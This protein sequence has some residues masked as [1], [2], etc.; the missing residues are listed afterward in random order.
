[1][2][3]Q[4]IKLINI[5]IAFS[6]FMLCQSAMA[7]TL[8]IATDSGA[9]GSDAGNAI[10]EWAKKIEE[11]TNGEIELDIFYQNELGGQQEV[12]DLLMMG[13]VDLMLNW[14]MTT[15]DSR[16]ALI[17]TPYMFSSW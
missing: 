14:P 8:R 16:V 9:K 10:E 11:K 2:N 13:E 17:Y 7:E 3:N 12:F 15:Y 4:K 1:M 6:S 5:G